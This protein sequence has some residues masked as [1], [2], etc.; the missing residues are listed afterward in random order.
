MILSKETGDL[1]KMNS[2]IRW[3]PGNVRSKSK[4]EKRRKKTIGTK[5]GYQN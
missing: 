3:L 2:K 1:M 5:N 4:S